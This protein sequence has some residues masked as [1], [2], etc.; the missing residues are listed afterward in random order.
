MNSNDN[1]SLNVLAVDDDRATLRFLSTILRS[2]GHHVR[3]A[4]NGLEAHGL[5]LENPPDLVLCDW[6]MPEMDGL[7]LCR[8]IRAE[9]LPHY[10]YF[11]LLTGKTESANLVEGL[12][13]GAD[14]FVSKPIH[15]SVLLARIEAGSRLL[16]M[17][18][19]LR[20]L[21]SH[22]P[23][24]GLFNRRMFHERF[25]EE[26][27]RAS[28]NNKPLSCAMIDLDFFKRVNDTHGHAAGD[29]VLVTVASLVQSQC[30]KSDI[31]CRYGGEEFCI[32]LP[33]TNETAAGAWAERIRSR[34]SD[35]SI[36]AGEASLRMTASLGVAQR[37]IDVSGPEQ[38][39]ERA[40]QALALAKRSGRNRVVRFSS[41]NERLPNL[42]GDG[43]P[44]D[45]MDGI[46]ARD[47]MSVPIFCP[48]E[49]KT[50]RYVAD[51]FL[52]LRIQS[53]PVVDEAGMI[54]G[55][56][57]EGNLLN[58]TAFGRGWETELREVMNRDVVRFDEDTPLERIY[59]FFSRVSVPRVV[60]VDDGRPTGVISRSTLLRW[61]R[62]WLAAQ[63]KEGRPALSQSTQ[64]WERR[65]ASIISIARDAEL[66]ASEIPRKLIQ[67]DDELMAGVVGEATRLQSLVNDM[68]GYCRP[69]CPS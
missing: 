22:D 18:R 17:E 15:Q 37:G 58:H 69:G 10:I 67:K 42:T 28:R 20:M 66:V 3:E 38:L 21:S 35:T 26:W 32:L 59:E 63:S 61:F 2:A 23:L 36:S 45:P 29:T 64:D 54:T 46:R 7:E 60:V 6:D 55:I 65:K 5:I 49:T 53:A 56:V 25:R 52:Q 1:G 34:L 40:D 13:A 57:T 12:T 8:M 27:E 44:S 39:V 30:R 41:L 31:L 33:H 51:V 24:T 47:V 4:T 68:L 43:L 48:E 9:E 62:N 14:D 50:V 16:H 11:I 19:R